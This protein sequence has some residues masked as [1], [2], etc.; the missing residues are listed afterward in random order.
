MFGNFFNNNKKE[1]IEEIIEPEKPE[2]YKVKI[3]FN[4]KT[5]ETIE[6]CDWEHDGSRLNFTVHRLNEDNELDEFE[7]VTYNFNQIRKYEFEE[8]EQAR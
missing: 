6:V 2:N 7:L 8:D 5:T 3:T 1:T 4:D